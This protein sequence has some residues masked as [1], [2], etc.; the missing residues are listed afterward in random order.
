MNR[1]DRELDLAIFGATGFTGKLIAQY[2]HDHVVARE[3]DLRWA[4]AGRDTDRLRAV[5]AE[6]GLP[7]SVATL[8]VNADDA[9]SVRQ[10]AVRCHTVVTTVGPYQKYGTALVAACAGAGTDYLDLCGEPLWMARQITDLHDAARATGA[11]IVFSCGFDSIPFDLGVVVLQNAAQ[12]RL[13]RPL[14]R[15]SA[16]VMRI[17][18]GFSGGTAASLIATLQAVGREPALAAMLADPFALTPGFRGPPQPDET[19]AV[20]DEDTGRWSGPFVM[21]MINTKNVHRTNALREHPWGRDFV[22]DERLDTGEGTVGR[23][24]ALALARMTRMQNLA[25]G[26]A[27]TRALIARFGL[28]Q[29]GQGPSREQRERG[30]YEIRIT[31]Q[32]ALGGPGGGPARLGVWVRGQRDPGYGSTCRLITESALCLLRDVDRGMTA[33]GI[34]TPGAALGL[35]LAQRLQAHAGLSFEV[36]EP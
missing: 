20:F 27:P 26:F 7:Q 31:G 15:V 9:R 36:D 8:K 19:G 34:W 33:G 14:T 23:H 13:G 29:P 24:K 16:R 6:L 1:T 30:F 32:S 4:L 18:G 25:L 10:L 5:H 11:R 21:A 12:Q 35:R 22:Y 3:P 17:R 2:I 28:P